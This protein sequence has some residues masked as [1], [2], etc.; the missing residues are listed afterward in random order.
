VPALA[1]SPP[2]THC[3]SGEVRIRRHNVDLCVA[4]EALNNIL[5]DWPQP[6]IDDDAQLDADS[7]RH[8]PGEGFLKAGCKFFATQP[9]EDDCDSRRCIDHQIRPDWFRQR[10]RPASS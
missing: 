5:P 2:A 4:K 8:Q 1:I 6:S 3:T 7:G 10:G 9:P